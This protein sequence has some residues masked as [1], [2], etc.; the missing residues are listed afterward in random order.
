MEL[1]V[2]EKLSLEHYHLGNLEKS[3]YYSNRFHQGIVE[4]EDSALR[5]YYVQIWQ[6]NKENINKN[7][8]ESSENEYKEILNTDAQFLPSP[9]DKRTQTTLGIWWNFN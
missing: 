2:F 4:G 5:K 7:K 8:N 3:R 6:F 1:Q 9:S